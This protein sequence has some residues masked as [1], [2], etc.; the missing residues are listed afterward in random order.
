MQLRPEHVSLLVDDRA[1]IVGTVSAEGVPRATRGWGTTI[2]PGE[3][4]FRLLLDADDETTL[5][6]LRATGAIAVTGACV[7][8]LRS[9][10]VKGRVRSIETPTALDL[11]MADRHAAM[12]F[13][14]IE[15]TD[16]TPCEIG[17]RLVP[18]DFVVCLVDAHVLFD[19]TPGPAAGAHVEA[20]V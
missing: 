8:T 11:A 16:G 3:S 6:N 19:Q 20:G 9:V 4:E 14:A 13:L 1:L 10:Q 18:A 15:E 5:E 2:V 17:H 12:M 7:R